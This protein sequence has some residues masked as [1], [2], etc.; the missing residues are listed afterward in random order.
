MTKKYNILMIMLF[1]IK[2][3][4]APLAERPTSTHNSNHTNTPNA[5][6]NTHKPS[7]VTALRAKFENHQSPKHTSDPSHILPK[8][9]ST[10]GTPP[11]N[12]SSSHTLKSQEN[13]PTNP[14]NHLGLSAKQ[15]SSTKPIIKE[16]PRSL[17]ELNEEFKESI[18]M[19]DTYKEL[20][21]KQTEKPSVKNNSNVTPKFI[22]K[23]TLEIEQNKAHIDAIT[24]K[25]NEVIN[26]EK[27]E[28]ENTGSTDLN[29]TKFENGVEVHFNPKT[30]VYTLSYDKVFRSYKPFTARIEQPLKQGKTY[31]DQKAD[32]LKNLNNNKLTAEEI[33]SFKGKIASFTQK[34]NVSNPKQPI[35]KTEAK[36]QPVELKPTINTPA[37]ITNPKVLKAEITHEEKLGE[38]VFD[39]NN[40][41]RDFGEILKNQFENIENRINNAK[42]AEV[43]I[44]EIK[45]MNSLSD[46]YITNI[47]FYEL[48]KLKYKN[49]TMLISPNIDMPKEIIHQ[50]MVQI[51]KTKDLTM[52]SLA[53]L[54]TLMKLAEEK[55]NNL[56]NL[57]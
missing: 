21:Q 19:L 48:E 25:F 31:T 1:I 41:E 55:L 10:K 45:Y 22:E 5:L 17:K 39:K 3:I 8:S 29:Y 6:S 47:P 9:S 40:P 57:N 16:K 2:P 38:L 28:I 49:E 15:S 51:K 20:L 46:N 52:K 18:Q 32:L 7:S 14:T 37:E 44:A 43:C 24:Q 33:A 34:S 56:N 13:N 4:I 36:S 53:E 35:T 26:Q 12:N 23:L 42:D 27:K 11:Q 50:R 30:K 54:D